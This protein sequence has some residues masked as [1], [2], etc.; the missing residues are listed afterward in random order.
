MDGFG[1]VINGSNDEIHMSYAF[2]K[3]VCNQT[4]LF[5]VKPNPPINLVKYVFLWLNTVTIFKMIKMLLKLLESKILLNTHKHTH[6][7]MHACA[8]IFIYLKSWM[9]KNFSIM[10]CFTSHEFFPLRGGDGWG[11][12]LPVPP[13]MC[14]YFAWYTNYRKERWKNDIFYHFGNLYFKLQ[15]FS[16]CYQNTHESYYWNQTF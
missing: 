4:Q 16:K 2:Y 1:W 12:V 8:H 14:I 15:N 7:H 9:E 11:W 6:T 10:S 13:Q 3:I 5:K